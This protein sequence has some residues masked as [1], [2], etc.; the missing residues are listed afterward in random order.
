MKTIHIF[1]ILGFVIL[2]SAFI[3]SVNVPMELDLASD[4]ITASVFFFGLFSGFFIVRQN[5]R[6]TR[7]VDTIAE[8][9]GLYSYLYRMFGIV[10]RIQA[11]VREIIRKHYTKIFDSNDWAYNE[12]HPSNTITKITK[13]MSSLTGEEAAQIAHISPFSIVWQN[14]A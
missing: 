9:D 13:V 14:I 10:P 3:F 1:I 6:Y 4:M 2:Y 11:E 8:R 12:F 5:E 7:I